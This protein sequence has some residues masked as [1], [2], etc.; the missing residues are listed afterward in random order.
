MDTQDAQA[1]FRAS[2]ER[3]EEVL[4]FLGGEG[5]GALTHAELECRL[6]V[7]GRELLRQLYQD[8]L[9]LRAARELRLG[10]VVGADG[11]ARRYAEAGH[12][13]PLSTVFGEVSINRLAYRH[14]VQPTCTPP[15]RHSTSRASATP[16]GSGAWRR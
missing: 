9:D 10:E 13:R 2:Q 14:K 3:F 7:Q 16:M 12:T 1:S 6:E 8:H 4:A 11:V 5:A 15:T